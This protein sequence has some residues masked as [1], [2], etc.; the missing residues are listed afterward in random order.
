MVEYAVLVAFIA[1]A[2]VGVLQQTGEGVRNKLCVKGSEAYD[3]NGDGVVDLLD[4]D[5][6]GNPDPATAGVTGDP[7]STLDFNCS[8][9]FESEADYG[10]ASD[11]RVWDQAKHSGWWTWS[12]SDF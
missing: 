9:K 4:L 5:I 12:E 11:F 7:D 10:E 3:V 1:V 6:I 8:G 2:L